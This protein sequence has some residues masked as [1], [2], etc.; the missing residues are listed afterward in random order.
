MLRRRQGSEGQRRFFLG[1]RPVPT[2][3]AGYSPGIPQGARRAD[4][5]KLLAGS[6]PT[7][8]LPPILVSSAVAPPPFP[9]STPT[10]IPPRI[11]PTTFLPPVVVPI[12]GVPPGDQPPGEEPP[13]GE[14]PPG[15]EPPE[16][17]EPP[18]E[19]EPPVDVP[20]PGT[21][22]ILMLALLVIWRVYA[23]PATKKALAKK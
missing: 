22:M 23:E 3:I 8:R 2:R 7:T 16:E 10:V 15:E 4:T 14:E 21:L 11:P 20:E 18:G 9:P 17:E 6:T 12:P 13:D 5:E 1:A 19:E